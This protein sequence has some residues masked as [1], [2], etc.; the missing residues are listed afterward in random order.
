MPHGTDVA[1][2]ALVKGRGQNRLRPLDMYWAQETAAQ[3]AR[4]GI[5]AN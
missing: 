1:Q 4:L 2:L 3:A 5:W